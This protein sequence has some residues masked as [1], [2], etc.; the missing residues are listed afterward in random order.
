MLSSPLKTRVFIK[1][2]K[3]LSKSFKS[4]NA[5]ACDKECLSFHVV[6][7]ASG[8]GCSPRCLVPGETK[9][10]RWPPRAL[11]IPRVFGFFNL[12]PS[13]FVC[14]LRSE[15]ATFSLSA[16]TPGLG[17][18]RKEQ[19][20]NGK[21]PVRAISAAAPHVTIPRRWTCLAPLSNC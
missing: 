17:C 16:T 8:F 19:S 18:T 1:I 15:R 13:C 12:T 11:E 2:L 20:R 5:A 7:M 14:F 4:F 21:G 3:E 6:L 9:P 10:Q